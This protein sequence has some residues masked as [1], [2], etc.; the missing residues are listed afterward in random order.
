MACQHFCRAS[1]R[2]KKK[3]KGKQT[4]CTLSRYMIGSLP[5]TRNGICA[6]KH[7]SLLLDGA[8]LGK[9]IYFPTP[10]LS[11]RSTCF[12]LSPR[13]TVFFF[14]F[15]FKGFFSE[16]FIFFFFFSWKGAGVFVFQV[17]PKPA[18]RVPSARISK[19]KRASLLSRKIII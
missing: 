6:S 17:T 2:K 18:V 4:S 15:F 11:T 16:G 5:H 7:R 19:R 8:W 10:K 9:S 14:F 1:K 12:K 13:R 3:K